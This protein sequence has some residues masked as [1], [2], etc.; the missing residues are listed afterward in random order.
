MAAVNT[1]L[2]E[3][4]ESE[5]AAIYATTGKYRKFFEEMDYK[6]VEELVVGNVSGSLMVYFKNN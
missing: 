3:H 2:K 4:P 6:F 1:V 5:G